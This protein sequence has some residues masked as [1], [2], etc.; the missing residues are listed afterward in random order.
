MAIQFYGYKK[1]GTSRKAEKDLETR[2]LAH[3]F[4]DITIAPPSATALKKIIAQSGLPLARFY[5]TSGLQYKELKIKDLRQTMTE[6]EQI[7]MLAGNG[8]LLKRPIVSD[9]KKA[10]VGYK[11]EEFDQT[12]G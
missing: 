2:G 5:N 8:Y 11:V 3:E 10:T 9:G 6:A 12:W 4:T 1:C 7:K